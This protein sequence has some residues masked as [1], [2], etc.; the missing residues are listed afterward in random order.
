[1]NKINNIVQWA[2][3][4]PKTPI[5]II[6]GR[7]QQNLHTLGKFDEIYFDDYPLNLRKDTPEIE[8]LMSQ[9]R[10]SLFTTDDSMSRIGN[11]PKWKGELSYF[12]DTN[13]NKQ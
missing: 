10:L 8:R 6:E 7:W 9:K 1:M 3:N 4:Y 2:K 11:V 13:L 5:H 12:E